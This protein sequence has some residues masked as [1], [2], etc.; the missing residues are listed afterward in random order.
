[1]PTFRTDNWPIPQGVSYT[2]QS[3]KT[4]EAYLKAL[5]ET[6]Q[7]H[8]LDRKIRQMQI[9]LPALERDLNKGNAT[10]QIE[11]KL[12]RL[13]ALLDEFKTDPWL[14]RQLKDYDPEFEAKLEA[15]RKQATGLK[16]K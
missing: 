13:N 5:R 15:M 3:K 7:R 14:S 6:A 12:D 10:G 2:D 9:D 11:A 16:K 4:S 1:M 8:A